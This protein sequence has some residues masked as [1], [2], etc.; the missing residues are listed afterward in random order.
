MNYLESNDKHPQYATSLPTHWIY[1]EIELFVGMN[2]ICNDQ[3]WDK[4]T[5]DEI[6]SLWI[7]SV[8]MRNDEE[9]I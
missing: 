1:S 9:N 7:E 3:K 4:F 6:L 5:P 8:G 2:L